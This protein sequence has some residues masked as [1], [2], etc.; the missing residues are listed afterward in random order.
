M[1]SLTTLS[2][3]LIVFIALL[4][5]CSATSSSFGVSLSGQKNVPPTKNNAPL[6]SVQLNWT[7][8]TGSPSGYFVE[9]STD[10]VSFTQVQAVP[11]PTAST[12]TVTVQSGNK[13]YF[14][15]RSYNQ[16]GDSGYTTNTI[17]NVP[18]PSPSPSASNQG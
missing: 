10:G 6:A 15:I 17:V 9:Q 16:G 13:Y 4:T 8:S 5:G 3:G 2:F 1:K 18:L 11:S 12:A 14:R 7:A